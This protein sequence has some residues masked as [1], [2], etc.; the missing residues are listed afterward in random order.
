V[1]GVAGPVAAPDAEVGPPL[2]VWSHDWRAVM[3]RREADIE[4]PGTLLTARSA[5]RS[6]AILHLDDAGRHRLL[7]R[8]GLLTG[9]MG[10]FRND[11]GAC[12]LFAVDLRGWGDTAPAMH[13]Y[14]LAGWGSVDRYLAY[15]TAALGDPVMAMRIRDALGAL[16]WLRTRP[17]VEQQRIVITGSG[18]GGLVALHVAAIDGELA[19]AV[20]WDGLASF[21]SLIAAER[22]PWPADAFLPRVLEYYDLPQL[23]AA[24]A[25]PVRLHGLRDGAGQ[26]ASPADLA[27]YGGPGVVISAET[28]RD[29]L[30]ATLEPLLRP[31]KGS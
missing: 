22:Y 12:H 28:H 20:T 5:H 29:A 2:Q 15:S 7:H 4:L 1:A 27:A 19:G 17:D 21:R 16:A 23:A 14:E 24:I 26:P 6:P 3:L 31:V 8:Q 30:L 10:F 25:C 11:G 9:A 18:L 13:P